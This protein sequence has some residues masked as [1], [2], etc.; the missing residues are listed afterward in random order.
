MASGSFV[1]KVSFSLSLSHCSLHPELDAS[2]FALPRLSTAAT[3]WNTS[4]FQTPL[5]GNSG[6]QVVS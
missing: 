1:F 2:N 5:S 3:M 4:E 6:D